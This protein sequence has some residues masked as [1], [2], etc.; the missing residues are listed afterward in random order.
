MSETVIKR[1]AAR[2]IRWYRHAAYIIGSQEF[3]I[4]VHHTKDFLFA[5]DFL[6]SHHMAFSSSFLEEGTHNASLAGQCCSDH[7]LEEICGNVKGFCNSRTI[8]LCSTR[9]GVQGE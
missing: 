8:S 3:S 2:M 1:G 7:L 9:N 5:K 6:F 4:G